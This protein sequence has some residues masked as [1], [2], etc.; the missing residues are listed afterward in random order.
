M[1]AR[2]ALAWVRRSMWLGSALC[3]IATGVRAEIVFLTPPPVSVPA[4]AWAANAPGI[5]YGST[6]AGY[7]LQRSQAWR[8][9]NKSSSPTAQN[10]WLVLPGTSGAYGYASSGSGYYYGNMSDRAAATRSHVAR[11]NAYRMKLFER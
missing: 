6:T 2:H 9:Q 10:Y 8:M 1:D 5:S 3:C 11:A 4:G 7:A